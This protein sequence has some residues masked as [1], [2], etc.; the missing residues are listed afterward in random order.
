MTATFPEKTY[1]FRKFQIVLIIKID[2]FLSA[3]VRR[4]LHFVV[5][6]LPNRFGMS[7]MVID[8]SGPNELAHL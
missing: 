1:R 7:F 8:R 2:V 4:P 5:L 6:N 3:A